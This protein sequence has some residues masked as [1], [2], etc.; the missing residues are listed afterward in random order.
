[1]RIEIRADDTVHIE[2]YVNAVGRDSRPLPSP[3]G[4][5]VEQVAPGVFNRA[6]AAKKPAVM[7]DHRRTLDATAEFHEDNIGLHISADINDR[8]IADKARRKELRGWSFGFSA[9]PGGE[10]WDDSA[11]PY[12]R[13]ILTDISLSE[14]SIID[15]EMIPCYVGTSIET[16]A[17]G[18]VTTELR[19]SDYEEN[20]VIDGATKIKNELL[21]MQ[22]ELFAERNMI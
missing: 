10:S 4:R 19:S 16:R 20:E 7:L 8:E 15:S 3:K 21:Y 22:F 9:N 18:E 13:R 14:V 5:F 11:K 17:E 2:G 6:C 1:M 12:P